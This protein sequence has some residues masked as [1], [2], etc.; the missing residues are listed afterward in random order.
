M[1][2]A[3]ATVTGSVYRTPETRFTQNDIAV[4]SFTLKLDERDE[5]LVRVIS[6]RKSLSDI[7]NSLKLGDRIMIDG[8][9]QVATSKNT[10]GV[11]KKFFEIDANDMEIISGSSS[12]QNIQPSSISESASSDTG[13]LVT[14]EEF[15]EEEKLIDDEEI[16]F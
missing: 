13:N 3:K 4:S 10:D 9:L 16:P 8:R 14:F 1:T 5:I 12:T 2:L 6:K 11:E 15:G 7:V